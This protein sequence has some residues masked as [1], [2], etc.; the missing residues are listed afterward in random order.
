MELL[1]GHAHIWTMVLDVIEY[2]DE[3][4]LDAPQFRQLE[5]VLSA[6]EITRS[7]R[8]AFANNRREYIAAHALCRVMLSTFSKT[9]AR[10][11]QFEAG[12]HGRPEI[13][14]GVGNLRF[15]ISHTR[16][17]VCVAVTQGDDIGADVEWT[18]RNNQFD[19]IARA[20]FS[21]P[22]VAQ[23]ANLQEFEKTKVFF[24]F[25]TLKE[26][27]IKAIGKGLAEPLD[28]FAFSLDPVKIEF[29]NGQ[30]DPQSWHFEL[31]EPAPEYLC[32]LAVNPGGIEVTEVFHKSIDINAL[33]RLVE[34][35][36]A[37]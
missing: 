30:D 33:S 11:W 24:S 19:D 6:E 28:G 20:K 3:T 8:F 14:G 34:A 7:N 37:G 10:D 26:A 35:A 25:W 4:A 21:K 27:Y 15:N 2:E 12:P 36:V 31:F 1:P 32:A 22:E 16:G 9:P 23:L 5:A 18:G 29:L 13:S 17:L